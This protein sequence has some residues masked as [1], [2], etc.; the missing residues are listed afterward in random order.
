MKLTFIFTDSP[1]L[2]TLSSRE[3]YRTHLEL[4]DRAL[5]LADCLKH[6]LAI[7]DLVAQLTQAN[8]HIACPQLQIENQPVKRLSSP[9]QWDKGIQFAE[10]VMILRF[11]REVYRTQYRHIKII[12]PIPPFV[13]IHLH[14]NWQHSRGEDALSNRLI[15]D[16]DWA[17]SDQQRIY[18]NV[19]EEIGEHIV[20]LLDSD[21]WPLMPERQW[22]YEGFHP[23]WG[24]SAFEALKRK[25]RKQD[26]AVRKAQ[27]HTIQKLAAAEARERALGKSPRK[28]R[29][30]FIQQGE[31]GPIKIGYSTNPRKR[32]DK[33]STASPYPLRMLK[34]VPGGP[35]LE[36]Q[37]HNRFSHSQL[38]GEWFK[39]TEE[40][41]EFIQNLKSSFDT[42]HK[43]DT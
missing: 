6:L 27:S 14:E 3:I 29:I 11:Q 36:R 12:H 20:T 40:L 15:R 37:L 18:A 17:E 35:A 5:E 22:Q 7:A 21:P 26:D 4:P 28:G 19:L 13:P 10:G 34:I 33:L 2:A 25:R 9:L 23:A 31:D 24:D 16:F 39:P 1:Q 8:L 42:N 30:Y 41:L 38:E 32:L 43:V